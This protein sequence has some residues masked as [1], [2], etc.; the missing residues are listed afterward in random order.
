[1][2][3]AFASLT[4]AALAA[5]SATNSNA[6]TT[7]NDG[8]P[9]G[10]D[11]SGDGTTGAGDAGSDAAVV[12][13]PA[14]SSPTPTGDAGEPCTPPGNTCAPGLYCGAGTCQVSSCQGKAAKS[15]PYAI[16]S[17]FGTIYTIGPERDN[18]AIVASGADCDA[19]TFPPLPN[20][21]LGD[22][23]VPGDAGAPGDGGA[24]GD[25]GYPTLSDGGVQIVTYPAPPS[26]CY[27]L[28]YDPS[29]VTGPQGLCW[30]GA[31]F[32]NSPA[33][34]AAAPGAV[35]TPSA[36]GVCVAPGATAISFWARS[37]VPGVVIK[38][39]SS[40][41]GAC[42]VTP[43]LE[44]DGGVPDPGT[45]QATCPGDTEFY[46]ALTTQWQNYMVSLPPGEPYDDEPN[47]GGGVWNALSVVVEP[48]SFVGGS[49]ILIKDIVWSD[50]S[51]GFDAGVG[52]SSEAGTDGGGTDAASE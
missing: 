37:S 9:Q 11:A 26:S 28:V 51:D 30:A 35:V 45:Q 7:G 8:G 46:L 22:A 16:A 33:T 12:D 41:P 39:G 5:C 13:S 1:M 2:K 42:L 23:G 10:Q 32:T 15:L 6:P 38:F 20:T 27:E 19:T 17:D 40:R 36:V 52:P 47:S 24:P 50:P 31:I 34:A 4:F 18:F 3:R 29:C 44:A 49:Y 25:A 48:Q 14:E 21:G 43:I